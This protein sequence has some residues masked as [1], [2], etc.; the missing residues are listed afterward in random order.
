MAKQNGALPDFMIRSLIDGGYVVGASTDNINP[1]SLDL[2]LSGDVYR[3]HGVFVPRDTETVRDLL[4]LVGAEK[5]DFT[6]PLERGVK[7]IARLN[8]T[9]ELPSRVYGFCNPKS[10]TGRNGILS[11]V[12]ADRVQRYDAVTSHNRMELWVVIVPKAFPIRLGEGEA[13][14]QLRFFNDDTRFNETELELMWREHKLLWNKD[15][16]LLPHGGV[17]ASDKD[18]SILL[19]ID[20]RKNTQAFRAKQTSKIFELAKGE[21]VNAQ[22][23]FFEPLDTSSGTLF[24]REGEFFILTSKEAVRIPPEL[25]CEMVPMDERSGE[26]RAHYAGFIDPGWGYGANGNGV[27]RPLTLEVCP[28]EDV[29]IRDGQPIAKIR[30]ERMI[31]TPETH[32]DGKTGSHYKRQSTALLSKHVA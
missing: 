6:Q 5:H 30:L 22:E 15:G 7:Y 13:L 3:T 26:L 14:S 31:D 23:D 10:S 19:T 8:E 28:F 21:G 20:I 27:G 24:L 2:S 16:E 9:V 11:R 1:A 32:Y 25:S 17:S 29:I 4:E 12:M 18:G